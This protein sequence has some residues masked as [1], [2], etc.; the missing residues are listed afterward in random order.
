VNVYRSKN[1]R[2]II[3][4]CREIF[5]SCISV[6]KVSSAFL[7]LDRAVRMPTILCSHEI[8]ET[9]E[10]LFKTVPYLRRLV[11]GFPPQRPEFDPWSSHVGFVV[12]KVSL[13]Q[14]F[15]EYFSFHYRFS[16]NRLLHFRHLPSGAD[17]TGK[18][19]ADV[20]SG[21]KSHSTTRN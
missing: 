19:V 13:E 10:T 18:L 2:Y 9:S 17:I 6:P 14:V 5:T 7:R 21:L 3:E 20:P 8:I 1:N 16:F 11:A 12:S 15:S 4:G